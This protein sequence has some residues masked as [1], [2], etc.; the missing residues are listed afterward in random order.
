MVQTGTEAILNKPQRTQLLGVQRR[1]LSDA[2]ALYWGLMTRTLLFLLLM[3]TLNCYAAD[4]VVIRSGGKSPSE[5]KELELAAQFYGL[6]LNIIMIDAVGADSTLKIVRQ[7][8][9]LAVA[10]EANDLHAVNRLALLRAL[11][12]ANKGNVPL[13]I[14]GI[15]PETNSAILK[16]W[17]GGVVVGTKR[18]E[19]S[20][21]LDYVVGMVSGLTQQLSGLEIP[22]PG[23][24]TFYF[25]LN[26][27]SEVQEI[28]LA[29][30]DKEL[31]PSFIEVDLLQQKIFLLSK[32][33]VSDASLTE[34]RMNNVMDA[35]AELAPVML[36]V[37]YCAG[38]HGWHT[39][40]H[41][42]NLT[43][44]DPWLR[45]PYGNLNYSSLL[46]EME[47]HDFH[48][49]IAFIP[50]NYDRSQAEVVSLFRNHPDRFSIAVH[51]NNH[52]HKEF[53]EYRSKSLA[54]Q[55]GDTKQA[56]SRM[57]RFHA[58]TGI[59]YDKVMIFPHSI[60]PEQTL[61]A[62]KTYNYLATINSSNVPQ[63]AIVPT[64]LSEIL[65]PVTLTFEGFPSISRYSTELPVPEAYVAI[66]Q[67]LGNP[68]F[69][70]DHSDFFSKSIGAFDQVADEVN[71]LEPTTKWRNLG[72]IVK[73]LYVVKLRDDSNYDVLAFSSDICLENTVGR[74]STFYV[75]KL[76]IGG[77]TIASVTVDGRI[78][79][80]LLHDGKVNLSVTIPLDG[81]SC[82]SIQYVND[83][84]SG[85]TNPTHDSFV[86]YLLRMGS[87]FRDIYLA[88]SVVGLA[89]IRFYNK[90]QL[91]PAKV[92]GTLLLLLLA[93]IYAG[94]RLWA[95]VRGRFLISQ[96]RRATS[97]T[98]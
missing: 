17:S 37:K 84:Q 24:K 77:Q 61:G 8:E 74:N 65:R 43:I 95:S 91:M 42:A 18:L 5:Q 28:L 33:H 60:A 40:H 49:T 82:V 7:R 48:T 93:M 10:L 41:Y 75:Q 6:E 52:D 2:L 3:S 29:R 79:P 76:E 12:R 35:F 47:R 22:F 88:K 85:S 59:P 45:E 44:D 68:L 70:Y 11:H 71:R 38:E 32:T 81:M 50:W 23:E 58:L 80:Y 1:D 98:K 9:T 69:F 90:H 83:L 54:V 73:H 14:F 51:G 25:S 94:F 30:N 36:F 87:D 21:R 27:K 39:L 62:L 86:V 63:N 20:H 16:S 96:S 72:E 55:V 57:D 31:A 34:W 97:W 53:T 15:T 78:H 64:S 4:L 19:S 26:R 46:K 89:I 13:L 66:N 92:L 67:F 56:L